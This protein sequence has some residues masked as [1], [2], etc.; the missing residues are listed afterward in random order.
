MVLIHGHP[1]NRTLWAPQTD[2]LVAA[3]YRVIT[4]DLRGYGDSTVRDHP[5]QPGP[6][7]AC[8]ARSGASVVEVAWLRRMVC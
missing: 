4:P 5:L 8:V 3:G 6:K 2:A 7:L 1:F